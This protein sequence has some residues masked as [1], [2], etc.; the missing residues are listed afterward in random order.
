M[1]P[2]RALT[3]AE[4]AANVQPGD[5]LLYL[6]PRPRHWL[7]SL[8]A[9]VPVVNRLSGATARA[10]WNGVACMT[11]L[12]KVPHVVVYAAVEEGVS[13][14]CFLPVDGFLAERGVRHF[15]VRPLIWPGQNEQ[16][17]MSH[18]VAQFTDQFNRTPA[19]FPQL[20]VDLQ[21]PVRLAAELYLRLTHI[22]LLDNDDP[23]RTIAELFATGGLL[24]ALM[25]A[26]TSTR[27]Q[28]QFGPEVCG[29]N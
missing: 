14:F 22:N 11:T 5:M 25:L 19:C 7:H 21:D 24:D 29:Y 9:L 23:T 10:D 13:E 6:E 1:L 12:N 28:F 15:A 4:I 16:E 2:L 3:F 26:Q 17:R 27:R 20:S 18:I 8:V